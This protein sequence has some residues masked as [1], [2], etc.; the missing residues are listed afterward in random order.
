MIPT[1]FLKKK[2]KNVPFNTALSKSTTPENSYIVACCHCTFW[3]PYPVTFILQTDT[4]LPR[5]LRC[6]FVEPQSRKKVPGKMLVF[7]L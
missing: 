1:P 6:F 4:Q 7:E 2:K 5:N 3:N